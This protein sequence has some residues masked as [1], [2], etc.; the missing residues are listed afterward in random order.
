MV[1]LESRRL[2]YNVNSRKPPVYLM[3]FKFENATDTLNIRPGEFQFQF[4]D[5]EQVVTRT[6]TPLHCRNQGSIEFMIRFYDDGLMG[7]HLKKCSRIRMLG[8]IGISA[9]LC[10]SEKNGCWQNIGMLAEGTSLLSHTHIGTGIT[11]MLQIID[12]KPASTRCKQ[13]TR[14]RFLS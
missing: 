8:P 6:Y 1:N 9:L 10:E 14:R 7:S 2:L 12:D 11:S 3:M 13:Y 5:A 4:L